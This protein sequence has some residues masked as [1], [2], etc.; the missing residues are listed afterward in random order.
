MELGTLLQLKQNS[1][2]KSTKYKNNKNRKR[3]TDIQG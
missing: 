3:L 2:S 1:L